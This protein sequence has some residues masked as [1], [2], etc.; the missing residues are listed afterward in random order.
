[1]FTFRRLPAVF[2]VLLAVI[3]SGGTPRA[4]TRAAA[5]PAPAQRAA[6]PLTTP[7]AEWGHNIG[8][9][10][11]LV[12][13]QQLLAYWKK[14]EKGSNRIHL[15]DIGRSDRG[16]G[17]DNMSYPNFRDY[18]QRNT[19]LS[20]MAAI[21]FEPRAVS[22]GG[23][24]GAQRVYA[25]AVSGGSI[26]LRTSCIVFSRRARSAGGISATVNRALAFKKSFAASR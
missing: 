13:Y 9:D 15:V 3:L 19:T 26:V 4:Q 6:V 10:Y 1:M 24:A 7:M 23:P 25:T 8:D 21:D 20:A 12:N 11:F 14:L 22:L 2:A 18:S 16:Q 17:F 5:P